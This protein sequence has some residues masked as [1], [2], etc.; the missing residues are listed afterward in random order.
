MESNYRKWRRRNMKLNKNDEKVVATLKEAKEATLAELTE[1]TGLPSKK[2][3]KSL[4]K[5]FEHELIDSQGRKYRLLSAKVPASKGN[6][7]DDAPEDE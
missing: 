1:K 2:V 7:E 6:E 3:F 4:K 5:L